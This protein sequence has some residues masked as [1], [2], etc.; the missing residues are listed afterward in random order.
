MTKS[1][2]T[3]FYGAVLIAAGLMLGAMLVVEYRGFVLP[4]QLVIWLV[5]ALAGVLACDQLLQFC[6]RRGFI[7]G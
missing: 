3:L 6:I 7:G 5:A 4:S 2:I 1:V